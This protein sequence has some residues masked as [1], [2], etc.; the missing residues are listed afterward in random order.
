M[1][2]MSEFKNFTI[3]AFATRMVIRAVNS[4][5]KQ[6][7]EGRLRGRPRTSSC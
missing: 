4:M 7:G 3:V 6:E 2:M 5:K 1:S